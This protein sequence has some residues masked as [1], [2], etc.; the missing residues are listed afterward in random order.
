MIT[1]EESLRRLAE[2]LKK[3]NDGQDEGIDTSEPTESNADE[4]VQDHGASEHTEGEGSENND[5]LLGYISLYGGRIL[6]KH[7]LDSRQLTR[8]EYLSLTKGLTRSQLLEHPLL[9]AFFRAE[10][11]NEFNFFEWIKRFKA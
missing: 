7:V 8:K 1:R 4:A 10:D 2:I 11:Q 5:I 9:Y 6:N 3:D